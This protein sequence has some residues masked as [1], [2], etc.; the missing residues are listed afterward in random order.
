[1]G[2][3]SERRELRFPCQWKE[4]P[5]LSLRRR[6]Q[7]E[8]QTM[9]FLLAGRHLRPP[10][11]V[12]NQ[13][14]FLSEWFPDKEES[15]LSSSPRHPARRVER[16]RPR[17]LRESKLSERAAG[18]AE[19]HPGLDVLGIELNG[20][21][22]IS[23]GLSEGI[24]PIECSSNVGITIRGAGCRVSEVRSVGA[25]IGLECVHVGEEAR[26]SILE[27]C[28]CGHKALASLLLPRARRAAE[29]FE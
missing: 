27:R 19:P 12:N 3:A 4:A 5:R 28:G 22:S 11:A 9:P 10:G 7:V 24:R 23:S 25:K 8:E 15:M 20:L 18:L 1:M 29:R 26:R 21:L 6:G 14:H 16:Q 13:V 17:H 2:D